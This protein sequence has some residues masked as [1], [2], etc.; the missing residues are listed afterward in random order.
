M[1]AATAGPAI[2]GVTQICIVCKDVARATAFYRDVVALPFLF[3]SNGLAFFQAGPVRL[4]LSRA[5]RPEHEN[6]SSMIY[7]ATGDIDAKW[8]ALQ[9]AGAT[10]GDP[11][12]LIAKLPDREVWLAEWR[13]T[14]GNFM[15]LMQ[16]KPLA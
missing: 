4:M 1:S 15:A 6:L 7:F 8:R 9:E 12:H 2:S 13:D 3:E 5:E 10:V 11:P 14:E 16:E